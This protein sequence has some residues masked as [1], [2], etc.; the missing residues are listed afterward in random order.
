MAMAMLEPTLPIWLI[1]TMH[2]P[3]WQL[4]RHKVYLYKYRK[5]ALILPH[6]SINKIRF[7]NI[8]EDI[9]P[10]RVDT[11]TPALD[12]WWRLSWISLPVCNGFLRSP[13]RTTPADLLAAEPFSI[14]VLP[15]VGTLVGLSKYFNVVWF[16]GT[17]FLPDSIGYVVGTNTFGLIAYKF[18]R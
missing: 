10:F 9:S 3:K 5:Y 4:G 1:D 16:V 14:Y 11:D 6:S 13:S 18:G 2:P 17:I 15:H 7:L 12:F 8:F